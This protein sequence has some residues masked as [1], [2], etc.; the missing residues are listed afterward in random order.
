MGPQSVVESWSFTSAVLR[1]QRDQLISFWLA[2]PDDVLESLWGGTA[3]Q[4][5]SQM[6]AE[7]NLTT[8]FLGFASCL[9]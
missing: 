2:C 8:F 6:V 7:L 1:G 9:A 3:G 4:V 5:T